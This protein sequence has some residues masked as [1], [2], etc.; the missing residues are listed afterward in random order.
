[1]GRLD[2]E[3]IT[4]RGAWTQLQT[5]AAELNHQLGN[6]DSNLVEQR[7]KVLKKAAAAQEKAI[8]AAET[9]KEKVA[10][11]IINEA[12][13]VATTLTNSHLHR[14]VINRDYD[15]VIV[16][17]ASMAPLPAVWY[18]AGLA[19][20]RV[21]IVGD[22]FQLPPIFDYQPNG[23]P[24]VYQLV[25]RWLKRNI[26][27]ASG[28]ERAV[29]D[30]ARD[31]PSNLVVLLEQHRMPPEVADLVNH[32]VYSRYRNGQFALVTNQRPTTQDN[33]L[34]AGL[35]LGIVD[36]SDSHP[37]SG[38]SSSGS[39]Y[40]NL[41]ALLDVEL[42]RRAVEKGQRSIGVV[43][44]YR[45]QA[46][47]I[48]M[49]LKDRGLDQQVEANTIH[50][51][52]GSESDLVIF[53]ITVGY[54]NSMYE[55]DGSEQLVNVA[56]SRTRR[57]CLIVAN[58]QAIS[59]NHATDSP[60]RRMLDYIGKKGNLTIVASRLLD[61]LAPAAKKT[62]APSAP[63]RLVDDRD[64]YPQFIKD[65]N[66]A[67]QEILMVSPFLRLERCRSMIK[68]L[69]P[70][71]DRGILVLVV[72]RRPPDGDFKNKPNDRKAIEALEQAGLVVLPLSENLHE[73]LALIDRELSWF[74]SLNILSHINSSD[75]MF[76]LTGMPEMTQQFANFYRLDKNIPQLGHNILERCSKCLLPGGWL[77]NMVGKYGPYTCC[78]L[79]HQKPS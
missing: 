39:P 63:I 75:M 37:W 1:M 10:N 44:A 29:K 6:W 70:A 35:K 16:D 66:R 53:D 8:E 52:Q 31:L 18:A 48:Q 34:L 60:T 22:F 56:L 49:M 45:A 4:A 72:T 21:V 54:K 26:F 46:N 38:R 23:Q 71:R 7:L 2:H 5:K 25:T 50:K 51:F 64:F 41:N 79:C 74:G 24:G 17:E 32:L 57:E 11:S 47:L 73:K 40:C 12:K 61:K 78:L 33:E 59:E 58:C 3:L 19:K 30:E 68:R 14:G 28:I 69:Q 43:T 27:Q 20:Q 76:R 65:A 13:L 55:R 62:Q 67:Q 15:C 77:W 36:T 9:E 42:A